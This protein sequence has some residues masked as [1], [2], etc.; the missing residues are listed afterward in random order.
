MRLLYTTGDDVLARVFVME[1]GDGARIECVESVQPPV[2]RDRKWVLIVST[3]KGCPVACPMCD[4]GG[5]YH[6]RLSAEEILAQID[7][8]VSRRYPSRH[9][10]SSLWKIQFARMGDPAFNDAVLEV[11]ERL[12]ARYDAPGLLP[13]ISTV[14]PA[15]RAGFLEALREIK[16][17]RYEGGRFQM[18]FSLHT[19][20]EAARSRLIPTHTWSLEAI[21][22]YGSRFFS[23]G[24][25]K[26]TLNF[27]PVESMPLDPEMLVGLF[28]PERFLVKLTP[29]NPTH[30]AVRSG[31]KGR[32]DPA[33]PE[34]NARIVR[35]FRAA[36][37]DT[38]LSIGELRENVIGSNCGMYVAAL[39]AM[40]QTHAVR[41]MAG[42]RSMVL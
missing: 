2:P 6:G 1:T 33:D 25:R 7:F 24:D 14:A 38:I 18:Q 31:L 8:L 36:G 26:I 37:F 15:G 10:P 29:V 3:L 35:A 11:L 13:S 12:P 39:D 34:G 30:A 41:S 20:D 9:V 21:A 5:H 23:P 27:A 17:R 42:A 28:S 40:R 32:I 19:T 4:A 22:E 16:Q